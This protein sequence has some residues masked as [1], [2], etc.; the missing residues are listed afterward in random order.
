LAAR[1]VFTC[2]AY[3]AMT[4]DRVYRPALGREVAL[5]ELAANA[6]MQFD[7][8]VVRAVTTVVRERMTALPP[9]DDVRAVLASSSV[10]AR[11]ATSA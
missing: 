9:V 11:F 2:D 3:H 5:A 10:Q 6:G 1:V 7:P 4:S 8:A